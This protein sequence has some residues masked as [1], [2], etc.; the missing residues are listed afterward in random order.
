MD[1]QVPDE[2][3]QQRFDRLVKLIQEQAFAYSQTLVGS[4][5]SVLIEGAS[6]RDKNVLTGRDRH[7]KTVHCAL[8][9]KTRVDDW[10]GKEIDVDITSART[11]YVSGDIKHESI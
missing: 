11:W 1:G 5:A 4:P 9:Q 3:A 2:V 10:I 7:Y 6:K 8:P